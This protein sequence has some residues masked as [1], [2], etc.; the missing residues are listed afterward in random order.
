MKSKKIKLLLRSWKCVIPDIL[1]CLS[2]K[3]TKILI[4]EDVEHYM[5]WHSEW[6][7]PNFFIC[8][9]TLLIYE[10]PFRSVFFYRMGKG[11]MAKITAF[12]LPPPQAVEIG[13]SIDG[14]LMVSHNF[15]VVSPKTA[16]KNLRIGPGVVIGRNGEYYPVIGDNVYI[17][18]NATV[19]GHVHIGN[20]VIIG[21]GAVVTADVPDNCV[22][23]GNPAHLLKKNETG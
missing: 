15:S 8:F 23:V 2:K 19:I 6:V 21:A 16:G 17:A 18:S 12:F 14:G 7:S 10:K 13:G 9:N 1:Y 22:C 3:D 11:F 5:K 20:N 4:S